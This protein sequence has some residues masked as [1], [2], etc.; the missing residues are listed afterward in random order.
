MIPCRWNRSATYGRI[1]LVAKVL[2]VLA[3][4]ITL[5]GCNVVLQNEGIVF[6]PAGAKRPDGETD[7]HDQFVVVFTAERDLEALAD[8]EGYPLGMD[9]VVVRCDGV[10]EVYHGNVQRVQSVE[11]AK[12][13]DKATLRYIGYKRCFDELNAE[14]MLMRDYCH[15]VF[16]VRVCYMFGGK[17]SF[18]PLSATRDEIV[19]L[20]IGGDKGRFGGR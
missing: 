17:F 11:Q 1:A 20:I 18:T 3:S 9:M 13:D 4:L 12:T 14:R 16:Q 15:V 2:G 19:S 10:R 6:V 5:V 7:V 8:R